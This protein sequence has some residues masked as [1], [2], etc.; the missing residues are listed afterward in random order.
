MIV[1]FYVST[2]KRLD[3][4]R[5]FTIICFLSVLHLFSNTNL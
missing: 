1:K 3:C 5:G 4:A 2:R